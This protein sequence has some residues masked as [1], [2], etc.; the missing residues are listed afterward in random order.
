MQ[1]NKTYFFLSGLPRSGITLLSSILNQNPDIYVGPTSPVLELLVGIDKVFRRSMLYQAFPKE[2]FAT[3]MVFKVFNDWYSDIDS[4]IIIDKNRAWPS[5][6]NAAEMI[7]NN[8]KIICPVRSISDILSSWIRLN[9]KSKSLTFVDHALKKKNMKLTDENR[10][11]YFM[12]L[13]IGTVKGALNA[14]AKIYVEKRMDLVHLVEYEDLVAKTEESIKGIYKF[15]EIPEYK[16]QY[17]NIENV[18]R[19]NDEIYGM[20]T[21]HEVRPTI[22]KNNNDPKKVL[23]KKIIEKYS[24]LEFWRRN[25]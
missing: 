14:L 9:R 11:E 3:N 21:M 22:L 23:G 16:H 25:K 20:P 15:L 8:V 17:D 24:G 10:C 6:I 2:Q 5:A 18:H 12:E 1:G 19:E 7:T 13:G 4:P